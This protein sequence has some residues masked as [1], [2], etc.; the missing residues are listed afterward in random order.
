MSMTPEVSV[1]A[2]RPQ[3]TDA[4]AQA[5]GRVQVLAGWDPLA[6]ADFVE[7]RAP[8]FHY[9]VDPAQAD[10]RRVF[11][12]VQAAVNRAH[13]DAAAGQALARRLV[14]GIAPGRYDEL[15]YLP[16]GAVP[17]TLW[18][19]GAD[20]SAV[21]IEATLDAGVP[22]ADYAAQHAAVFESPTLHPDIAAMARSCARG[23]T[24]G[25]ACTAV[26]W[27]RR[28]GTQLR[29]LTIAN[30]YDQRRGGAPRQSTGQHQALALKAENA[31]RLQLEQVQL[32][33]HQDTLYLAGGAAGEP[34]PRAFVHRSLV[35]GDI[36]FIFG[37]ATAYFLR[38]EIRWVGALRSAK[39]GYVAAPNTAL[40]TP[41]GFVFEDCD[42]TA[43]PGTPAGSV[44]F[45]RQWFNGARCSPYS[46]RG[47]PCALTDKDSDNSATR[48][49]RGTLEGVG[50]MVVLR[51][52]LGAHLRHDAPWS[53]W[54]SDP[55]APNH[56]PVQRD[57][58][59]FWRA[60]QAAGQDPAAL[61]YR[62]PDPPEPFL[63]EYRNR[64]PGA[65]SPPR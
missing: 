31:D 27:T 56:R 22:A 39:A 52:H 15:V 2:N 19:E 8:V 46:R 30:G 24:L 54:Q 42:F 25:T 14:I 36:D 18:G 35:A 49:S 1:N 13:A 41:Y 58:E 5:F 33:G 51:S 47:G 53:P 10:G 60:L 59:D 43:L 23:P 26:L 38:S 11:A 28:A 62:R 16:A 17:I 50:K 29:K 61:G 7:G 37:P 4:Q 9:L 45:A 44:H 57:S 65:G 20:A 34:A 64:G 40:G 12:T 55:A 6:D 32:L 63:A 21:R 3:L 48:V